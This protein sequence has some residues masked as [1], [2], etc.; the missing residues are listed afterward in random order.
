MLEKRKAVGEIMAALILIM[1]VSLTGVILFSTSMRTTS[2]QGKILKEELDIESQVAQERFQV[3]YVYNNGV[4]LSLWVQNYGLIDV[5]I[6]DI[7]IDGIRSNY[8]QKEAT[9]IGRNELGTI[10]EVTMPIGVV[11]PEYNIVI[12]SSRGVRNESNWII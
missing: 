5:S 9:E 8:Y 2:A 12:I 7:Y 1:I 10:S 6:V 4:G 3:L 11:G